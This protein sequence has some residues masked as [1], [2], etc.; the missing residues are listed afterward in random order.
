VTP[1]VKTFKLHASHHLSFEKEQDW[2]RP[3]MQAFFQTK[4]V[5][6]IF[7]DCNERPGFDYN[8]NNSGNGFFLVPY[9]EV[10]LC[11]CPV[12]FIFRSLKRG[13]GPWDTLRHSVMELLAVRSYICI[14]GT[15]CVN[16]TV[17]ILE[18]A[19]F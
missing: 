9:S 8:F 14:V 3:N 18:A 16:Q 11:G 2:V 10:A 1:I 19:D 6:T 7:K 5:K 4:L 13:L 15:V 17:Q 12:W